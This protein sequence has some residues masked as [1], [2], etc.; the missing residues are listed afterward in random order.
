MFVVYKTLQE[1]LVCELKL[2]LLKTEY[3]IS[4]V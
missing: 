2:R 1:K 4:Q 3:A